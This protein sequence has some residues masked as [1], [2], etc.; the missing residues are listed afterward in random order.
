MSTQELA[1][2]LARLRVQSEVDVDAVLLDLLERSYPS[3]RAQNG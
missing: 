3:L 1:R 2:R